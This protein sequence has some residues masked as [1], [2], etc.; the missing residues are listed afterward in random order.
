MRRLLGCISRPPGVSHS[1]N[2][3]ESRTHSKLP[4]RV[5]LI[6]FGFS[7]QS[8]MTDYFFQFA[9][10]VYKALFLCNLRFNC[11]SVKMSRRQ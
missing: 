7:L 9:S 8:D 11:S 2:F 6:V 5:G 3:L 1:P 4:W 10:N